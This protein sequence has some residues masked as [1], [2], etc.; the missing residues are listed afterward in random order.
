MRLGVV[1]IALL[2]GS[3]PN[4]QNLLRE[5]K[6]SATPL[7]AIGG[8]GAA[9][10]EFF[11]ISTAWR[12]GNGSIAV[13]DGT[14]KEIRVFDARGGFLYSYGRQGGGPGEFQSIRWSTHFG[15]T[16]VVY[17]G[18]LRRITTIL[19]DG[20]PRLIAELPVRGG[21]DRSFDVVGRL[22]DGRWLVH[23]LAAPDLRLPLGVQRVR[24]SAGLLGASAAGTVDWLAEE[25]DLSVF[26]FNPEG[27]RTQVSVQVT[28]FPSW[29]AMTTI[30]PTLWLGNSAADTLVR[31]DAVSGARKSIRLPDP[32]AG[33]T[34]RVIEAA[35]A[36]EVADA[37]TQNARNVIAAKYLARHL[38]KHLP[39]F[40]DLIPGHGDELWVQRYVDDPSAPGQYVVVAGNGL[41]TARVT[42]APS[43]RVTD[44]GRD[45]VVGIRR[46]LEGLE[47]V[48]MY[49]L[50]R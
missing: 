37:R 22:N 42:V 49:A 46:D 47:S 48:Q 50:S 29:F 7:V 12:L 1:C 17:D 18:S 35:R 19:L 11:R 10:T 8:E 6:L 24:G 30:G 25:S 26:V 40:R 32:P 28:A 33:I 45:Y 41:P 15:D 4:A 2:P 13:V 36:R 20:T 39:A 44:V 9:K 27:S 34:A 5:W 21:E 23:S 16:A 31:I 14:S 3:S 43:F 38:P